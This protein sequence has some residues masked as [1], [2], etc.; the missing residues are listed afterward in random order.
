MGEPVQCRMRGLVMC[1]KLLQIPYVLGPRYHVARAQLNRKYYGLDS[2][3]HMS[4]L[5]KGKNNTCVL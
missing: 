5:S 2:D 3:N 1:I 4:R